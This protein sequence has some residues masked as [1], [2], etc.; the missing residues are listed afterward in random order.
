MSNPSLFARAAEPL[1]NLVHKI[2]PDQL[3]AR[4]PDTEW[5]VRGLV[6]HLLIWGP[7]M[8][9]AGR[10]ESV[11]PVPEDTDF[12][13]GDWSALLI[14]Q[15]ERT[16]AAWGVPAS[17]EGMTY[18]ASPSELPAE[19]VGGMGLVEMLAHGWDLSR[20]IGQD[21]E[22]PDDVVLATYEVVA[23]MAE[24]GRDEGI[25]GPEV[26]VAEDAPMFHRML[27]L[28]GRDPGWR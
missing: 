10:K 3:A 20:A 9:G 21:V 14:A 16:V 15:I 17:W 4:T 24:M 27:G 22:W 7:P 26:V 2:K 25:F 1:L 8:E 13:D 23:G 19:A 12:T 5:D 18:M 28:T 6:N 11:T